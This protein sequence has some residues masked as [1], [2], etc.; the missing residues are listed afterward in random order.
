VCGEIGSRIFFLRFFSDVI[1]NLGG[2]AQLAGNAFKK[3]WVRLEDANS[4]IT[5]NTSRSGFHNLLFE[6]AIGAAWSQFR[7]TLEELAGPEEAQRVLSDLEAAAST[8]FSSYSACSACRSHSDAPL[9]VLSAESAGG[10]ICAGPV[11]DFFATSR[12]FA[13]E[14]MSEWKIPQ[15]KEWAEKYRIEFLRYDAGGR[16]LTSRTADHLI[17]MYTAANAFGLAQFHRLRF[18]FFHEWTAHVATQLTAPSSFCDDFCIRWQKEAFLARANPTAHEHRAV[19]SVN[20]L[21]DS[22]NV[23][24]L[25]QEDDA[26]VA[27]KRVIYGYLVTVQSIP[28]KFASNIAWE[29]LAKLS[30]AA[31]HVHGPEVNNRFV[32]PVYN[33]LKGRDSDP[34]SEKLWDTFRLHRVESEDTPFS[35]FVS[36]VDK[37]RRYLG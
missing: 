10:A 9:A 4:E 37:L 23:L 14:L 30:I 18:A 21:F 20:E 16:F 15:F 33:R 8:L 19:T 1:Q 35:G 36:L 13:I 31:A 26:A 25:S 34:F 24:L 32:L 27:I 5:L 11:I 12:E 2:D 22:H 7:P 29:I 3:V 28:K 17:V 6:R